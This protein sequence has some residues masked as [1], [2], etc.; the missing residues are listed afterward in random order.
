MLKIGDTYNYLTVKG[1]T[2][3]TYYTQNRRKAICKCICGNV[4][5]VIPSKLKNGHTKSCGCYRKKKLS[6]KTHGLS[7]HPLYTVWTGMKSRCNPNTTNKKYHIY[8]EKQIKVCEEWE[9]NFLSFYNWAQTNN[10]IKG[11]HLDRIDTNGNYSPNNCQFINVSENTS[12]VKK[13][14]RLSIELLNRIDY[15]ENLL[16]KYNIKF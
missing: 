12:K 4:T 8:K 16:I 5:E 14:R 3:K 9:S 15:L 2:T 10:Y 13:D 1:F 6:R 7:K 11:L